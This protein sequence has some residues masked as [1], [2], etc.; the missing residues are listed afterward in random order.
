M[1][2]I[3]HDIIEGACCAICGQQ[4]VRERNIQGADVPVPADHGH[5]VACRKCWKPGCEHDMAIHPTLED[6]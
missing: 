1:E 6:F 2:S 4:F 5:A 3:V